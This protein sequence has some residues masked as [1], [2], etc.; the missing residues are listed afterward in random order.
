MIVEAADLTLKREFGG[1][2]HPSLV[3]QAQA[4]HPVGTGAGRVLVE[5]AV[6]AVLR[7]ERQLLPTGHRGECAQGLGRTHTPAGE[8]LKAVA[9]TLV[10][11]VVAAKL[12]VRSQ[13]SIGAIAFEVLP[14]VVGFRQEVILPLAFVVEGVA[15]VDRGGG[16]VVVAQVVVG[17]ALLLV[18][19]V[20][21]LSAQREQMWIFAKGGRS[22]CRVGEFVLLLQTF[23]A[24]EV[25]E[26]PHGSKAVGRA[27]E[28]V[29]GVSAD[30]HIRV[31]GEGGKAVGSVLA[32][33]VVADGVVE[34]V[35]LPLLWAQTKGHVALE[36]SGASGG[37]LIGEVK[38]ASVVEEALLLLAVS[39]LSVLPFEDAI[40]REL[41]AVV[42][43]EGVGRLHALVAIKPIALHE[44]HRTV[45]ARALSFGIGV[46]QVS[47]E[48]EA[49]SVVEAHAVEPIGVAVLRALRG[50]GADHPCAEVLALELHVHHERLVAQVCAHRLGGFSLLAVELQFV[51]HI[52]GK[53]LQRLFWVALEEVLPTQQDAFHEATVGI[54]TAVAQLH[55]R[56]SLHQVFKHRAFLH[57]ES[58]GVVDQRVALVEHL[59]FRPAGHGLAQLLSGLAH[60]HFAHVV[61]AVAAT[62]GHQ[63]FALHRL[64][65]F[66][67][68]HQA[69]VPFVGDVQAEYRPLLLVV[70]FPKGP[71]VDPHVFLLQLTMCGVHKGA[72]GTEERDFHS[73]KSL[74]GKHVFDAPRHEARLLC[75][76]S[77]HHQRE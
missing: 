28:T 12:S 35:V 24:A 40:G 11:L 51:D 42:R 5:R 2:L 50:F 8:A 14:E 10:A 66:V 31:G 15:V 3:G 77:A 19:F 41:Q 9:G 69:V 71:L 47:V 44:P 73:G 27:F 36:T 68:E 21:E 13:L 53:V 16:R 37:G 20:H 61:V 39:R 1:E 46:V 25:A 72:V 76:E 4:V 23:E 30:A 65:A 58:V 67:G 62:E 26:Q 55:A 38:E 29:E 33:V 49:L 48:R 22:L 75:G 63:H 54:K 70:L 34:G 17:V 18:G 6:P 43:L 57:V 64:V 59:E 56:Q 74:F 32:V 7:V 60:P 52:G 45:L